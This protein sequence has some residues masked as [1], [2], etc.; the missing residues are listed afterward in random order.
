MREAVKG[1]PTIS[2][3]IYR[4]GYM[5]FFEILCG[6][7]VNDIHFVVLYQFVEAVRVDSKL[8]F[9]VKIF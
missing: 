4:S 7:N 9:G 2:W 6:T 5:A 3:Q 8:K 1:T